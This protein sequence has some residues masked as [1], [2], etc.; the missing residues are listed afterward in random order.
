MVTASALDCIER[1]V[2][3]TP[4]DLLQVPNVKWDDIGGLEDVK[5]AI[6]DTVGGAERRC[7]LDGSQCSLPSW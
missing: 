3:I 4:A 2:G 6:M 7:F 1:S 5:R